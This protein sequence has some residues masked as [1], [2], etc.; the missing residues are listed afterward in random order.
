MA[1]P[2]SRRG[3]VDDLSHG[4]VPN[5]GIL[6]PVPLSHAC[7]QGLYC[8]APR[9]LAREVPL[10]AL[11]DLMR[12]LGVF[13]S[14]SEASARLR[15]SLSSSRGDHGRS[16]RLTAWRARST[17]AATCR[18]RRWT[19]LS[20]HHSSRARRLSATITSS[21]VRA[22]GRPRG[23]AITVAGVCAVFVNHR[24]PEPVQGSE[25]LEALGALQN[26]SQAVD[27]D[28]L[29]NTLSSQGAA[30]PHEAPAADLTCLHRRKAGCGCAACRPCGAARS[31]RA[32]KHA[33]P[34]RAGR[35]HQRGPAK[36]RMNAQCI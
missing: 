15:C 32:A 20:R 16:G 30:C 34:H 17:S 6:A 5:R 8:T 4:E 22:P 2:G 23:D 27:I 14:R 31:E 3:A 36:L 25:V 24:H 29:L 33:G 10:D 26:G 11:V 18:M 35:C 13:L 21:S 1:V 9:T 7:G 28:E 12:S 19:L